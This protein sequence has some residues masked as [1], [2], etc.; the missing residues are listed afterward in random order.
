ML[1]SGC[2]RVIVVV[3]S[4]AFFCLPTLA[5][6]FDLNTFLAQR[7]QVIDDEAK[8]FLGGQLTLVIYASSFIDVLF[9][10]QHLLVNL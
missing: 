4:A 5:G 3:L 9:Y 7:Q 8:Q 6:T 2:N 10:Q 1:S